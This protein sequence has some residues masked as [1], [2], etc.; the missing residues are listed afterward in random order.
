L[1]R[2]ITT[3]TKKFKLLTSLS[4]GL[5]SRATLALLKNDVSEVLFFTYFKENDNGEDDMNSRVLNIDRDTAADIAAN[6]N[7]PY[8]LL[9]L[10]YAEINSADYQ[11]FESILKENTYLHHNYYLAYK[12][13]LELPADRLHL[14][15]N[16]NEIFK[17]FYRKQM[18]LPESI[19]AQ[20]MT[21]CY[22][23]NAAEDT[24]V[25][26]CFQD[27]IE[28]VKFEQCLNYDPYD[29]FYWEYRLGVW[30]SSVL[31]ESDIAH[32]TFC[33]FNNRW[34]LTRILALPPSRISEFYI[35]HRLIDENW[36]ILNHWPIN[37][38]T[39]EPQ[40]L[41]PGGLSLQN[42]QIEGYS[43]NYSALPVH[44]HKEDQQVLFYLDV[45]APKT[46][47]RA[48]LA[49]TLNVEPRQGYFLSLEMQSPYLRRKL[50]GRIR[51]EVLLDG[52]MIGS[53][54]VADWDNPNLLQIVFQAQQP[55][56]RIVV[57][58]IAQK[59]CEPWHW[60]QAARVILGNLRLEKAN[61]SGAPAARASSPFMQISVTPLTIEIL[62]CA[63][64]SER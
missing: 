4:A 40:P 27:F 64:E 49:Q 14:R 54:D 13:L 3:L 58:V 45:N 1:S 20:M 22:A 52:V 47:D 62:S 44:I 39:T 50:H 28:T 17:H 43:L 21:V 19:S 34:L 23:K 30:H 26:S 9:P 60:G 5:D 2:Q 16:I 33:L 10:D 18:A 32:D 8:T 35:L 42:V 61:Y 11:D 41:L 63:A 46:G 6:L 56:C 12:Y 37:G 38:I 55:V 15:S 31:L 53:E 25:Q 57:Q 29:L 36:P 24:F 51:Y 59:D 7:L 48:V